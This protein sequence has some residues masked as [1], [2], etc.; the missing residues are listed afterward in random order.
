M[1]GIVCDWIPGEQERYLA[2]FERRALRMRKRLELERAMT[3]PSMQPYHDA[4]CYFRA[5]VRDTA[6]RQLPADE[7]FPDSKVIVNHDVD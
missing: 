4:Q 7:D 5:L 3:P 1:P 2:Y 6:Q